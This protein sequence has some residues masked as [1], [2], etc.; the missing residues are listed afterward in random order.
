M[1][2]INYTEAEIM[3]IAHNDL[4][5]KPILNKMAALDDRK[6]TSIL[7]SSKERIREVFSAWCYNGKDN[8][9]AAL[10]VK[11]NKSFRVYLMSCNLSRDKVIYYFDL[12]T[13]LT[14]I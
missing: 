12:E 3:A 6:I 5:G 10:E 7:V 9:K 14:L 2:F 11:N 13:Y 1:Q 8:K 4:V